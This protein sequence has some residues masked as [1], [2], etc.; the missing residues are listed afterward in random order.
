VRTVRAGRQ[1][2]RCWDAVVSRHLGAG[3]QVGRFCLSPWVVAGN[4]LAPD[5]SLALNT[6][7]FRRP[8]KERQLSKVSGLK[9][10]TRATGYT[11][12]ACHWSAR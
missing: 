11:A 3:G 1:V 2:G 5:P 10:L 4:R 12:F 7:L 6:P 8:A 9:S